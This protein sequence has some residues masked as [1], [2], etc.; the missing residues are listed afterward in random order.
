MFAELHHLRIHT[1]KKHANVNESSIFKCETCGEIFTR[2]E[3]LEHHKENC[4]DGF[5]E[6]A[7]NECIYFRRGNCLKGDSCI[8]KHG[9]QISLAPECR[10]GNRCKYMLNNVCSFFHHGIGVQKPNQ[11]SNQPRGVQWCNF[12]CNCLRLPNCPFVHSN[13]DFPKLPKS[14]KPPFWAK[15]V[16]E[17]WEEY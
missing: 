8:Y 15:T 12:Q 2:N 10:N 7:K 1:Q 17:A 6:T 4:N 13:Q 3:E 11:S 16:A 5:Q 14:S 9:I